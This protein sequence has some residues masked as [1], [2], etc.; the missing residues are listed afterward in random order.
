MKVKSSKEGH[1][2][3]SAHVSYNLIEGSVEKEGNPHFDN[4]DFVKTKLL[5]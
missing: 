2:H 3:S 1:D 4:C 5:G